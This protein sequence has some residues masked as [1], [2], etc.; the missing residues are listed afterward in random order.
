M[1]IATAIRRIET[2]DLTA[3]KKQALIDQVKTGT[4]VQ[5]DDVVAKAMR[6]SGTKS[7]NKVGII[8]HRR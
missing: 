7:Q 6:V 5:R 4:D 3:E 2:L 8:P 1:N